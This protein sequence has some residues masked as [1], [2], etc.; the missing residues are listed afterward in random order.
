MGR[1]RRVPVGVTFI[2]ER[3]EFA[4]LPVVIKDNNQ[5]ADNAVA[6][7]HLWTFFFKESFLS[8]FMV[9][10]GQPGPWKW[11]GKSVYR[12]HPWNQRPVMAPGL[13]GAMHGFR[14]MGLW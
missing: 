1:V 3:K 8:S 4:S 9:S 6:S 2:L 12:H 7:T 14:R 10:R 11:G 5:K 13:E